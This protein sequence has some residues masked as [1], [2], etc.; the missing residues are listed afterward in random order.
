MQTFIVHI[1]QPRQLFSGLGVLASSPF[2]LVIGGT[3]LAADRGRRK[4]FKYARVLA[5]DL[6]AASVPYAPVKPFQTCRP[7]TARTMTSSAPSEA[8]FGTT[9]IN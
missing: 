2:Q 5:I 7:A 6:S 4:R 1:R 9:G 8:G 3:I